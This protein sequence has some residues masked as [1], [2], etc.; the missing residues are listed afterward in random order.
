MMFAQRI[1]LDVFDQ[2]DLAC[3]GLENRPVDDLIEILP[4]ALREKLQGARR[5]I[6]RA[7]ETFSISV[8]PDALK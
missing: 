2:N 4:I 8:L 6:G 3:S 5:A 1:K 7:P